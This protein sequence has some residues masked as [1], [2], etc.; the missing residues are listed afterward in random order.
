MAGNIRRAG[1]TKGTLKYTKE[2][3]D[4]L[5]PLIRQALKE[6]NVSYNDECCLDANLGYG[7]CP[8]C[9]GVYGSWYSDEDQVNTLNGILPVTFNNIDFASGVSIVGASEIT[10]AVAGKYNIQFSAQFD[11]KS[12]G[13]P[14]K[15]VNM[16][17]RKNGVDIPD[18]NGRISVPTDNPFNIVAWNYFVDAAANDQYQLMWTTDNIKIILEH[19]PANVGA[20]AHPQTPSVILTVN[21][22]G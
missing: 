18:S 7:G 13:G 1:L 11:H 21:Q 17:F 19:F 14:G 15:T 16:W 9:T 22:V 4:E 6:L 3:T 12:G 5:L 10:F 2:A 20:G 8:Q